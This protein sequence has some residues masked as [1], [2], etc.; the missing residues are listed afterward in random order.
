M[1]WARILAAVPGSYMVLYPF[2]KN[3]QSEYPVS[4]FM[5][6]LLVFGNQCGVDGKRWKILMEPLESREDL[7]AMISNADV[8]L[9]SI[10]H[11]GAVSMLDPLLVGLPPVVM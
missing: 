6:S 10:R 1:L 5:S 9:D 11:S 3:W 8:Y 2:N 4:S 7:L